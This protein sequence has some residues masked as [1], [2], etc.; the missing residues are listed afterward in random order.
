MSGKCWNIWC[1]DARFFYYECNQ[2][3]E[4]PQ[5]SNSKA[6]FQGNSHFS[7]FF[8]WYDNPNLPLKGFL[9]RMHIDFL[10]NPDNI[11]LLLSKDY[12]YWL[13]NCLYM[14]QC[15]DDSIYLKS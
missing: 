5:Q 1:P 3:P 15:L 7:S 4:W 10:L 12:Y 9:I 6:I 8:D 11:P 2:G 13:D 14:Q